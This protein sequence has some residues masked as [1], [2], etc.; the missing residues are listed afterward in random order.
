MG[1]VFVMLLSYLLKILLFIITFRIKVL[2]GEVLETGLNNFHSLLRFPL[3]LN[4]WQELRAV[5]L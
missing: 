5:C 2:P 3:F 4:L 1:T